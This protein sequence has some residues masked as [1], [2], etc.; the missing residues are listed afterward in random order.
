MDYLDFEIEVAEGTAGAYAVRVLHSPAGEASGQMRLPFDGLALQNRLQ[1]LQIALLRSGGTRRRIETP[2]SRTVQTFGQELWTALFSGDVLARYEASRSEAK[3]QD[4]GIRIKLR[5]ESPALAAL[6]WE[7]LFDAGR[8]DYVTLSA[9]TP[10]VRYIPLPQ[11]M[12]P[13]EVTPPLRILGVA[14]SP[15]DMPQLELDRERQR[16]DLALADLRV[17]GLVDL[18]W[19]TGGTWR[20]LQQMLWKGP[21]HVFHFIGHGGFD[22][23]RGEGLVVFAG[24]DGKAQYMSARNLGRLLGDHEPLRL[25]ILNACESGRGDQTDVF[26]STAATLVRRGTPA[27]VAMQYEITDI[28]AIEFSRSFYEAVASGIPVD[29][30]LAEARK[31]VALA[32]P[33]TLE[34]GTPVLYMRAP[35]GVLFKLGSLPPAAASGADAAGAAGAAAAGAAATDAGGAAGADAAAAAG[36]A[37]GTEPAVGPAAAAGVA[38][39][40]AGAGAAAGAGVVG[41]ADSRGKAVEDVAPAAVGAAAAPPATPPADVEPEEPEAPADGPPAEPP[42]PVVP[43]TASPAGEPA[44]PVIGAAPVA[45]PVPPAPVTLAG[46]GLGGIRNLPPIALV[47]LFGAIAIV[48]I[49]LIAAL[50][51]VVSPGPSPSPS[52]PSPS[53]APTASASGA[54]ASPSAEPTE[55]SIEPSVEP[56]TPPTTP[57][58]RPPAT[59]ALGL[60]RETIGFGILFQ[61]DGDGDDEIYHLDPADGDI[62]RLTRNAVDD[63]LPSWSPDGSTIAFTRGGDIWL[64]DRDGSDQRQLT[65]NPADDRGP[66]WSPDGSQIVFSSNV[67]EDD[68]ANHDLFTEVS[69]GSDPR[70]RLTGDP[71]HDDRMPAWGPDGGSIVFT[72]DSD[73]DRELYLIAVDSVA[74]LQPVPQ[75]LTFDDGTDRN[76]SWSPDGRTI[77]FARQP[78]G[79]TRDIWTLRLDDLVETQITTDTA[80]EG[81]PV[82]APDG[83]WIAFYRKVG[84]AFHLFVARADGSQARDMTPSMR[85]TSLDPSWR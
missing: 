77:I 48:G 32:I 66:S 59:P 39:A 64:M 15:S 45:T 67:D 52:G 19:A 7:Y 60:S 75:Q 22:E 47:T 56:S 31:G 10:L 62:D 71:G 3:R 14:I 37:G 83:T 46:T 26:S 27:V 34:W 78:S 43:P 70:V 8:G 16:L 73:G 85:G 51:A 24:D 20:D 33:D 17:K 12:A 74:Q 28:A 53:I 6:P 11:V 38:A 61:N 23:H 79:A 4:A 84:D 80:D 63:R 55:A 72:S 1:A 57:P 13:L 81:N 76:P 44:S 65:S 50:A 82:F 58:S 35:D 2:E 68:P 21:W 25:A 9:G 69:D 30:S 36:T 42:P 41:G 54:T 49:V 18:E 29:A 5:F 40:L